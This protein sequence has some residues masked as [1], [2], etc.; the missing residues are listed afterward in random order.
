[1]TV[2]WAAQSQHLSLDRVEVRVS[3]SRTPD[4]RLFK[5]TVT[6]AG[7]LSEV[8]RQQLQQAAEACPVART[9][10]HGITV[11]TRAAVDCPVDD[12]DRE[13][14]PPA[15]RPPGPAAADRR[16][17]FSSELAAVRL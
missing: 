5:R 11:E 4:G 10:T 3:H 6:L 9:L 16:P 12:A 8:D 15:T 1:M 13:I 14:P 2:Q 17:A 7:D